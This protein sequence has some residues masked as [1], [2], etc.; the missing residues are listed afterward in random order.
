MRVH[1]HFDEYEFK[2][3]FKLRRANFGANNALLGEL[4]LGSVGATLEWNVTDFDFNDFELGTP[5]DLEKDPSD[6]APLGRYLST[7][8]IDGIYRRG[9]KLT[10][11]EFASIS[12]RLQ[13][14]QSLGKWSVVITPQALPMT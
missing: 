3:A 12:A 8:F 10:K 13:R 11:E 6:S 4:W 7:R 2:A 9:V 5:H 14:S 1:H